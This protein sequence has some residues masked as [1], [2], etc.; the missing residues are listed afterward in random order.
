MK[1]GTE[2]IEQRVLVLN[3]HLTERLSE[4]G[5]Q[6]LSPLRNESSR[7]GE[8]L[9]AAERPKRTVAH[10]ARRGIAV[11]EKPEGIRV[12]THFFNDRE[13]IARLVAALGELR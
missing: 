11:T 12:A 10:L 13:D 2:N 1:L 8:T 7:S 9:V 3:R 5:W 4:E 6:V